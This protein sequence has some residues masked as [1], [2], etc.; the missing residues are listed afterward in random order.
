MKL[1]TTIAFGA[2][3][4]LSSAIP[5]DKRQDVTLTT[6]V[7]VIETVD[8]VVTV[9]LPPGGQPVDQDQHQQLA[10]PN[11]PNPAPVVHITPVQHAAVPARTLSP[12][13]QQSSLNAAQDQKN[14]AQEKINQ[15][16]AAKNQAD[17]NQS[18]KTQEETNSNQGA[19]NQA[20]PVPQP[21]APSIPV[22]TPAAA[23]PAQSSA[24]PPAT[25]D[26]T[27]SDQTQPLSGGACGEVGG[28]CTA[29]NVTF[30]GG[31]LGACGYSNDTMTE[32]FFALAH[33]ALSVSPPPQPLC[34]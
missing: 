21:L 14:E 2:L 11:Q 8:I 6:T 28:T 25:Q 34:P 7:D 26:N 13:A 1:F 24:A 23:A 15:A 10:Q 18:I 16:Q 27:S 31:G 17:Q 29:T 5:L 30:Y 4:A 22:N 20:A 33:G 12:E 32:D 3:V 9:W 19:Q